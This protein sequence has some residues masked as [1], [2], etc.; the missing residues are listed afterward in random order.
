MTKRDI[1]SRCRQ[2][3]GSTKIA[4]D[5]KVT[6]FETPYEGDWLPF[7]ITATRGSRTLKVFNRRF[8]SGA[9]LGP[10][11]SDL[12]HGGVGGSLNAT[13][14]VVLLRA[15]VELYIDG[16]LVREEPLQGKFTYICGLGFLLDPT[17]STRRA[18]SPSNII[19][20]Y[21]PRPVRRRV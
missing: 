13:S 8:E 18:P 12:V 16:E 20:S 6:P 19:D 3:A 15:W 14:Q 1:L 17:M 10:G 11:G 9:K 21:M 2:A 4:E 7:E 5:H